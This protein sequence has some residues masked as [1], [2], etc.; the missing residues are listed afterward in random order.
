MNNI[1]YIETILF[2]NKINNMAD[3]IHKEM[4]RTISVLMTTAFAFVAG[5]VLH[6]TQL[7]KD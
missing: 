5:L 2:F 4:L 6:G 3:A 1:V 7:F